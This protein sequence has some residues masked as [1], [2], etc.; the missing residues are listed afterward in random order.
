[1]NPDPEA[2]PKSK[3]GR[4]AIDGDHATLTFERILRH[5]PAEVWAAIIQPE[6]LAS[7]YMAKATIEGRVGGTVDMHTGPSQFHVTGRVLVWDP[8]RAFEHEWCVARR[9]EL[10]EGEEAIIRW[11]LE[12]VREGTRLTLTH[13][14][15]TKP[16]A[17][18]FAPG[19]H[20]LLD[21]L[22]AHLDR[23]PL[24]AFGERYQEVLGSYPPMP[25]R[26]E[27]DVGPGAAARR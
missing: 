9:P 24:P 14:R 22:E 4:V 15:L 27:S 20:A 21:R 18:G 23:T 3:T 1:M 13:R 16:T 11:E 2:T 19:T 25:R 5:P 12:P 6:A 8:P 10:P 17:L 26:P 7:W